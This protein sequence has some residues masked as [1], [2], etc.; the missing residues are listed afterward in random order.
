MPEK[1]SKTKIKAVCKGQAPGANGELRY[2]LYYLGEKIA[3]GTVHGAE[4][5]EDGLLEGKTYRLAILGEKRRDNQEFEII[6]GSE[7]TVAIDEPKMTSPGK[8]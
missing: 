1:Q 7:N 5:C 4:I 2:A 6:G 8:A 3:H